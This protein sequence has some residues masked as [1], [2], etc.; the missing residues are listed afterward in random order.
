MTLTSLIFWSS[1]N[2]VTNNILTHFQDILSLSSDFLHCVFFRRNILFVHFRDHFLNRVYWSTRT[3]YESDISTIDTNLL[4]FEL[5]VFSILR[6]GE[7]KR[8]TVVQTENINVFHANITSQLRYSEFSA[9]TTCQIFINYFH[10]RRCQSSIFH[11]LPNNF[12]GF[13]GVTRI[14]GFVLISNRTFLLVT[15]DLS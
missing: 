9:W 13:V 3:S 6:L 15:A 8:W 10:Q 7:M 14:Q 5:I 2:V 4:S 11:C 1:L 12:G